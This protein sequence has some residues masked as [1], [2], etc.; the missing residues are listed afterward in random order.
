MSNIIEEP[1]E[2][3]MKNSYLDYA[4]SVIVGRALPDARDGLKPV[5]RRILYSMYELSNFHNKPYKKSARIVGEALG[6]YHPHGD[7]AIYDS[8]VRM[9]QD[10]SLRYTLVDGQ[11]N[12]GSIDGDPAAA[13]RYC[14]T[15]D[16]LILTDE[17]ILP[18]EE[19]S[20]KKEEKIKLKILSF[21]GKKNN[22]S[23][24]FNSGK[25]KII[26]L[27][28]KLG[29]SISGSHNHP[30]MCWTLKDGVPRIEWKFLEKIKI[31]DIVLLNR[32][33]SLFSKSD[34]NLNCFKPKLKRTKK[35]KLPSK[36]NPELAF[37]LGALVSEGSFHQQKILFSNSDMQF[38]N[39]VKEAVYSQFKNI[40]L[41][42]RE[43]SGNCLEF[44]IYHQEAVSFLKNIGLKEEKSNKKRIPF[45]VLRSSKKSVSEFLK[46][47][48]EGDGSVLFKTDKR[49]GGESI[50]LT[51]NSKSILLIEQLKTVLLNFGI[52]TTS[53]YKD[54]RNNCF[55][56]II[57][58]QNSIS[59]FKDQVGFFSQRKKSILSKVKTLNKNRMSKNDFIPY[60]SIYLRRKYGESFV[61]KHN[62]DRY[63]N[64]EKNYKKLIK[65]VDKKDKELIDFLLKNKYLFDGI[66]ELSRPKQKETVYS[67]RVDSRCH[68]FIANGFVNHNT[69]VRMD[70]IAEEILKDI[71][72][73]TVDFTPNFDGTLKEPTVLPS[74]VPNLL[75]NGSSG[76][77]VGMATNIPPHNLTE[78]VD[79]LIAV[80]EGAGEDQILNM[81]QGPDFPTG[82]II[83][84]KKGIFEAYK[85]GKGIIKLRGRAEIDEKKN[86]IRVTEIP[87]QVT[88][89]SIIDSVVNAV[90]EKKIEGIRGIHDRSDKDGIEL[91]FELKRDADPEVVLNQIYKYSPLESSFGIINLVLVDNQPR[92][93]PLKELLDNFI[94]FR[95]EI[96]TKRC[97]FELREAQERAHILE[98]LKIA[99]DNID[100]V[101]DLLR[102][103]KDAVQAKDQLIVKYALSEKQAKAILD[104]KLSKL[105]SMERQKLLDEYD[106]LLKK[107]KGL[108]EILADINKLLEVIKKELEEV[109]SM[110]GDKRKT[111]ISE[112]EGE[113]I[114]I[115]DLI[116]DDEVVVTI[117]GRGYIK[118]VLLDEYRAQQR[119]GKGVIG[120]ETKDEDI[121]SDVLVTRNHNYLLF[122]TDKGQVY[123]LKTY[124]IPE[125]GR[126]SAG[127][128]IINL[129]ELQGK[130]EKITAWLPVKE[131]SENEYLVMVTEKGVVKRTSLSNF[132][133]PRRTGI[134]AITLRENDQLIKVIK[135]PGNSEIFI[136]T[137]NGQS[138]RFSETDAREIGRTGMGVIGI[139]L[140]GDDKVVGSAVCTRPSVIT[141]TENGF[142]KRTSIDE[143]RIQGRGGSGIINIKTAGRNGPVVDVFCVGDD[144]QIIIMSNKGQAIRV[145]VSG[146]SVIGRNTSG[147]RILRLKEGEKVASFAVIRGEIIKETES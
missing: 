38:Y 85:T 146:I 112:F 6:K 89:T 9:A 41:Y 30:L 13:M 55:K 130:D 56:L 122:F 33:S 45:S 129:L 144:D 82:G 141:I 28:T 86:M 27:K 25:H 98:G 103:A 15:G 142:G 126:Y 63:P 139:R 68:S 39:K 1:I 99:L 77:A 131:F 110:Y 10:F 124:R 84:G 16:S 62:F 4:M 116:P 37:L 115:E 140:K 53:P 5:H 69:E 96:V 95:K 49:H 118:R 54:K 26:K 20:G 24:F 18:I 64:L 43:I 23:R 22:A 58:G 31:N 147:V 120:T 35:I 42:E 59:R 137:K 101:V 2:S 8:L 83:M 46:A 74:R 102:G 109:R 81:V 17:G 72:K 145:P 12:F 73:E 125:V 67:V 47:L 132:S 40:Q 114:F 127:K 57:S 119:G 106:E 21:A 7:A 128:A 11:G 113:D 29:Y 71:E 143:Y 60:I 136:A 70:K 3:D 92:C 78:V 32:S 100:D 44:S 97:E 88:K 135:T 107:I 66:K 111:E 134:R 50:E 14:I 104:M 138:I 87:Y 19:I 90:K 48:F 117:T 93:L 133:R 76:I 121:V 94:E 61:K 65:I 108:K 36:M 52:I 75:V 34:L 51:Y 91:L 123:W 80:I 105:I 79:A